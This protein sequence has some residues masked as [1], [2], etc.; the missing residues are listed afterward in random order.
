MSILQEYE[1]HP[2]WFGKETV[3]AISK[4]IQHLNDKGIDVSYSDVVYKK[5]EWQKFENWH[6]RVYN[7]NH[8]ESSKRD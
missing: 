7:I 3:D 8:G 5:T 4:Y 2:K 6:K 1:E